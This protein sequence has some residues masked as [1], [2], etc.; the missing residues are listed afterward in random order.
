MPKSNRPSPGSLISIGP[1]DEGAEG[2]LL[3]L[4]LSVERIESSRDYY[5]EVLSGGEHTWMSTWNDRKRGRMM[6]CLD[7]L[8]MW[9]KTWW[10]GQCWSEVS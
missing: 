7:G 4:V 8:T 5:V 1:I 9:P 2:K 6:G 3:A 10:D